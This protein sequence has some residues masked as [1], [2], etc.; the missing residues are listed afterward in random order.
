MLSG[1]HQDPPLPP[2]IAA[3]RVFQQVPDPRFPEEIKLGLRG[4]IDAICYAQPVR[5]LLY[6]IAFCFLYGDLVIQP[7]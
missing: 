2:P 4:N 5:D 7:L 3:G 6:R 1:P